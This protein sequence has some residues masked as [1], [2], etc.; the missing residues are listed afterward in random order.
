MQIAQ[1]AKKYTIFHSILSSNLKLIGRRVRW[2]LRS[3]P[4]GA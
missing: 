4:R 2:R 3:N 1:A